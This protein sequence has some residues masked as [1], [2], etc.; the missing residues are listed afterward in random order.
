M[1]KRQVCFQ[2]E[3]G[4]AKE[5]ETIRDET[6]LPLSRQLELKLKG[7]KIVRIKD[8][9]KQFKEL[10]NEMDILKTRIDSIEIKVSRR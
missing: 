10:K 8:I 6:G 1:T 7:Y 4:Q 3:E 9:E 2:L 5:M